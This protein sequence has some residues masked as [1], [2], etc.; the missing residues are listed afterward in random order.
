MGGVVGL[1]E[2]WLLK[3]TELIIGGADCVSDEV[4]ILR[5]PW[6]PEND[7]NADYH[8][9]LYYADYHKNY[10]ADNHDDDLC[11]FV[12]IGGCW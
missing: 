2:E 8:E 7:R 10:H 3:E 5:D 6:I 11:P 9:K 12:W 4:K 1:V